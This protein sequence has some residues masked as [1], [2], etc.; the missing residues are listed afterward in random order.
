MAFCSNCGSSIPEGSEF[1]PNCGTKVGQSAASAAAPQYAAPQQPS[2]VSVVLK[3]SL[4]FLFKKPIRLWGISLL[5]SLILTPPIMLLCW[6]LPLLG[7]A[8]S[9]VLQ[10]GM[11]LVYLNGYRGNQ[12]TTDALFHG[13]KKGTF[14]RNAWGMGWREIW[15]FIWALIPF[16]G[17]VF[18]I[19]KSYSYRFVPYI[20]AHD[21][22]ISPND[23]L[24]KSMA[25]TDGY[26]GKMFLAD[27][28]IYVIAYAAA[29]VLLLL[30]QIPYVGYLFWVVF[31]L[32]CLLLILL[33]PLLLGIVQAAFYDE[34]SKE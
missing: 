2:L 14:V 1:C 13:F 3:K 32:F 30:A 17:I 31:F 34:I 9:L 33:L 22:E 26:K 19:I 23:A 21:S 18:A 16:A 15:I 5:Y 8:I 27:F 10:M 12:V 11:T 6:G 4:A 20:M 29:L 7:I 28:L 24:R 25:Q